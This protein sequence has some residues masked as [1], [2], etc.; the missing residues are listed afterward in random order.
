LRESLFWYLCRK[1]IIQFL[2]RNSV[3]D[4][5]RHQLILQELEVEKHLKIHIYFFEIKNN[6]SFP[7][8]M[9]FNLILFNIFVKPRTFDNIIINISN[10][11][12]NFKLIWI[13]FGWSAKTFRNIY[14]LIF[15]NWKMWHCLKKISRT[16]FWL[17]FLSQKNSFIKQKLQ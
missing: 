3:F 8:N 13:M 15:L 10:R 2:C 12:N 16:S 11:L 7:A 6:W 17:W 14:L 9:I 4:E 1:S 5:F